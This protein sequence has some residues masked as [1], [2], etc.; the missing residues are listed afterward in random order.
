MPG[1]NEKDREARFRVRPLMPPTLLRVIAVLVGLLWFAFWTL[2]YLITREDSYGRPRPMTLF[3]WVGLV[4]GGRPSGFYQSPTGFGLGRESRNV[5]IRIIYADTLLHLPDRSANLVPM[6][7]QRTIGTLPARP[8]VVATLSIGL[9]P[10][11]LPIITV[12]VPGPA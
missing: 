3:G 7:R 12:A 2:E 5:R 9:I 6:T 4:C 11:L 1:Q 8:G 10:E